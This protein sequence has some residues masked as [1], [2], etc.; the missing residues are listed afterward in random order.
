MVAAVGNRV[1]ALKRIAM[2]RLVL[3]VDLLPGAWRWMEPNEL[4][5]LK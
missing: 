3:P 4:D 5:L 2:G 1:E